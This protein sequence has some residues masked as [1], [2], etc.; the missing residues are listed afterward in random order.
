[1][2]KNKTIYETGTVD[3]LNCASRLLRGQS[4]LG[5]KNDYI[6]CRLQSYQEQIGKEPRQMEG[7]TVKESQITM[8]IQMNPEDANPVGNV[9]GGVIM[10]YV[11]TAAGAVAIRHARKICVTASIDRLDF[12][13]PVYIGDLLIL[14]ASI[15][16]V[17]RTSMEVG[18]RVEAENLLTGNVRHTASAYLSFVAFDEKGVPTEVPPLILETEEENRRNCEAQIRRQDR[19]AQKKREAG[20]AT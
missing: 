15:T 10:K 7:K 4:V 19:L 18:V 20:C 17:G 2:Q 12:H 5:L 3:L 13:H 8:A 9:H 6:N 16:M 11:D 14:K 1:V